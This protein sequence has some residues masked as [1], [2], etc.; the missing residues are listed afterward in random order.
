MLAVSLRVRGIRY[1]D[2]L[3]Y[4]FDHELRLSVPIDSMGYQE[5]DLAAREV[6]MTVGFCDDDGGV[7]PPGDLGPF[8]DLDDPGPTE[9]P[10]APVP[11]R[12]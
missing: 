7:A 8:P 1:L 12:R 3:E 9:D 6:I 2:P 4:K 10:L 11:R 5:A